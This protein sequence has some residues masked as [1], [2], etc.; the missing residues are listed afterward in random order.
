MIILEHKFGDLD[1]AI[2]ELGDLGFSLNQSIISEGLYYV[3]PSKMSD[4][5]PMTKDGITPRPVAVVF[6]IRTLDLVKLVLV[7]HHDENPV[8]MT[9]EERLKKLLVKE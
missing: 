5:Y 7:K 4:D 6:S 8:L 1:K 3:I 9:Y 2:K